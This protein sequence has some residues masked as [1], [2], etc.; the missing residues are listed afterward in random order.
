MRHVVFCLTHVLKASTSCGVILKLICGLGESVWIGL[1]AS[2][3]VF[4]FHLYCMRC[5]HA[6][7]SWNVTR[8]G[9]APDS[10]RLNMWWTEHAQETPHWGQLSR[11]GNLMYHRKDCIFWIK[12]LGRSF[13]LGSASQGL[14]LQ[15]SRRESKIGFWKVYSID[16]GEVSIIPSTLSCPRIYGVCSRMYQA[17]QLAWCAATLLSEATPV[18]HVFCGD[19]AVSAARLASIWLKLNPTSWPQPHCP[20]LRS[21]PRS[22]QGSSMLHAPLIRSWLRMGWKICREDWWRGGSLRHL[23]V[24]KPSTS[25]GVFIWNFVSFLTQTKEQLLVKDCAG[26][27]TLKSATQ[28][29]ET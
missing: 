27:T 1:R 4:A 25:C 20:I 18:C 28:I 3:Q 8:H 15:F 6:H 21:L 24:P 29:S 9:M 7:R 23:C 13:W 22:G 16:F 11:Q 17:V 5:S 26:S 10:S 12:T 19:V 2:R 14:P